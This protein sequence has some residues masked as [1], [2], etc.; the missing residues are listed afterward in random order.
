MSKEP[1]RFSEDLAREI[2]IAISNSTL[3]IRDLCKMHSHWPNANTIMEWKIMHPSFGELYA[4]AKQSQVEILVDEIVQIADDTT[5]D[6]L[7]K[8]NKDGDEYYVPNSEYI[9]RSRIRI[10]TRK[11]LASKLIPKLYGDKIQVEKTDAS[12][13]EDVLLAKK[14]ATTIKAAND[15]RSSNSQG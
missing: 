9:N 3:G 12:Q 5:H 1:V 2:C 13:D 7:T 4:R 10:D 8:T 15:G 11:W 6:T 14:M